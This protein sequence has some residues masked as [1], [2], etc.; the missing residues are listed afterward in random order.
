MTVVDGNEQPSYAR[1]EVSAFSATIRVTGFSAT[2]WV[3]ISQAHASVR[4]GSAQLG[5]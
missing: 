3:T 5:T 4:T 1:T 2:I